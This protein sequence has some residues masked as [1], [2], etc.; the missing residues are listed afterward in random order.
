MVLL[1][2]VTLLA[3]ITA[4]YAGTALGGGALFP[5]VLVQLPP[6]AGGV[7]LRFLAK[8]LNAFGADPPERLFA[9]DHCELHHVTVAPSATLLSPTTKDPLD[10]YLYGIGV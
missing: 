9:L 3:T 8:P 2:C 4:M 10:G 7:L 6:Q 5:V 1:I